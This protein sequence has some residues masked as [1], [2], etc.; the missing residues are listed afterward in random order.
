MGLFE[1][2]LATFG[3]HHGGYRGYGGKHGGGHHGY[4]GPVYPAPPQG[5]ALQTPCPKCGTPN[6]ATARFCQQCAAS[7]A[8]RRCAGCGAD[9]SASAKFCYECG[10]AAGS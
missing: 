10:R 2:L 7:L 1:K 4:G 8:G 9:M 5:A 3:G 6:A